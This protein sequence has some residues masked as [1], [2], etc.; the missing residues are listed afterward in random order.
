[1]CDGEDTQ[2]RRLSVSG[3]P[4][5]LGTV[6]SVP[7]VEDT[8]VSCKPP[9]QV[10]VSDDA[11]VSGGGDTPAATPLPPDSAT[12]MA[13]GHVRV[14]MLY[15]PSLGAHAQPHGMSMLQHEWDS[16]AAMQARM[17]SGYTS[18]YLSLPRDSLSQRG[19]LGAPLPSPPHTSQYAL[20]SGGVP[21]SSSPHGGGFGYFQPA[22]GML[23]SPPGSA[24]TAR[25]LYSDASSRM[26]Q[27]ASPYAA[28]D[29]YSVPTLAT[30]PVGSATLMPSPLALLGPHT[31]YMLHPLPGG[32]GGYVGGFMGANQANPVA[33][34]NGSNS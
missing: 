20:T 27:T 15:K 23:H 21:L 25:T 31:R 12:H 26:S 1:M 6:P 32:G 24:V 7:V 5:A 29:M 22:G 13:G 14:G 28:V 16:H 8:A 17:A 2:D 10:A 30:T 18:T 9:S 19:V 4:P 33:G 11:T 3:L 34:R